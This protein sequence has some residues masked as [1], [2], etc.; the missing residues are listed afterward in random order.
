MR[1]FAFAESHGHMG[2]ARVSSVV[3]DTRCFYAAVVPRN[4]PRGADSRGIH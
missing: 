2:D 1:V 4:Y 3:M